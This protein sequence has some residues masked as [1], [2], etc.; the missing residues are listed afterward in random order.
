MLDKMKDI[1]NKAGEAIG[2]IATS[3]KEGVDSVTTAASTATGN[4]NE[5]AVRASTSQVCRILEIAIDELKNRP[6]AERPLSLTATVN[7]GI[8][9]LE[10]QVHLEPSPACEDGHRSHVVLPLIDGQK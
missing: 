1:G 2:G 7:L 5:K 6:L 9:A 10:M 4:L 8:A 3:V